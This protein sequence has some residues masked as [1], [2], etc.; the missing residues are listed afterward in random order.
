MGIALSGPDRSKYGC[1]TRASRQ[2]NLP[3]RRRLQQPP[4]GPNDTRVDATAALRAEWEVREERFRRG[5]FCVDLILPRSADEL[6]DEAAFD[7]DERLP[8][9]ADLWPAARALTT[10]LLEVETVLA[11][12]LELGCGAAALPSLA[13]RSR[14][15][16]VTAS[17]YDADA[18]RFVAVNAAR[19]GLAPLPTFALD[20]RRIPHDMAPFQCVVAADVMY[21]RRNADA[22]AA[23]L[24]RL[25]A[26]GG[27]FLL[28][29]PGRVHVREFRSQMFYAGWDEEEVATREEIAAP[30]APP[31]RVRITR[32]R[33][34]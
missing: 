13:L 22:V 27:A 30:G 15:V 1:G 29:D 34:R 25:V 6:I 21:E 28:A 12:A 8:Y 17:D 33:A 4:A 18:L 26:S 11:P 24:P 7:A 9:W 10:Y 32:W 31:L 2:R 20:W 5:G 23:A 16:A 19:N 3:P 14:G